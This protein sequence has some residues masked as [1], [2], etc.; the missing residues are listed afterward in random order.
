MYGRNR[1]LVKND[2]IKSVIVLIALKQN[3]RYKLN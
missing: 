3:V 1:I 2:Q